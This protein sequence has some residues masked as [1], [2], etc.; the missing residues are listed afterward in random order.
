[1]WCWGNWTAICERMNLRMNLEPSL[2]PY[3]KINSKW[4]KDLNV[5]PDNIKLLEENIGEHSST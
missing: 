5:R 1:M 3:I 4:S 2:T